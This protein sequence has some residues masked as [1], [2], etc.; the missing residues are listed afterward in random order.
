[1][2][3]LIEFKARCDNPDTV[4]KILEAEGADYKGRDHQVDIYFNVPEGRFKLRK[5]Q[6]ENTLVYYRREDQEGP[7][8]SD[9]TLFRTDKKSRDLELVLS[10][11]LG[12]K[13]VVDKKRDIYFI[14]N[15][16]F[17][18]DNVETLGSF[19]EVEV[20]GSDESERDMLRRQCEHYKQLFGVKQEDLI[21]GSYSDMILQR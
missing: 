11:A 6:I 14:G 1:M 13:T 12:I 4:R 17:H 16:K 3:F 2:P 5:G 10:R 20:I 18:I 15:V 7:K 8:G 9:V 21:S 19:I